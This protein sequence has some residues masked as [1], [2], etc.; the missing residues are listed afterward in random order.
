MFQ[1][2]DQAHIK[3]MKEIEELMQSPLAMQEWIEE[4]DAYL[5]H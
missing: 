1:K 3:A 5:T 2:G 4:I